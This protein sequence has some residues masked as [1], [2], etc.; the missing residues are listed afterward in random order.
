[1]ACYTAS[2]WIAASGSATL[3]RPKLNHGGINAMRQAHA[4]TGS[5]LFTEE[6]PWLHGADLDLVMGQTFCDWIGWDTAAR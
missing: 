3:L 2:D 4:F 6:S 5:S 1:M